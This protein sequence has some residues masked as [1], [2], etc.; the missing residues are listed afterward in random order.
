MS[1]L[2]AAI[3]AS[4]AIRFPEE[5]PRGAACGCFCPE[6]AS[7]LIARQGDARQWHF[8]H[9]PGQERPQCLV[10]AVNLLHRITVE[11][12]QAAA[13]LE[14]PPYV[15]M[16]H[17]RHLREQ[18]SWKAQFIPG[19]MRWTP[20]APKDAPVATGQLDN[21][22]QASLLVQIAAVQPVFA[23]ATA[24]DGAQVVFWVPVP[25]TAALRTLAGVR[26]HIRQNARVFWRHQPDVFGLIEKTRA[27]LLSLLAAND[28]VAAQKASAPTPVL[29]Q[30]VQIKPVQSA[31]RVESYDWAP[32]KKP[33]SS[34][35]YYR[36]KDGTTW[37]VYTRID[38]S[39]SI[40]P[41]PLFEGWDEYLPPS[42]GRPSPQELMYQAPALIP[43]L[44]FMS[45]RTACTR[46]SSNPDDFQGL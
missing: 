16:V 21:G 34:F 43:V 22:I 5:V 7:P 17:A 12:L 19:S 6:C 31:Q 23:P 36:L 9:E 44:T 37:I 38:G 28:I 14:L 20:N 35:I 1:Q 8:A 33:A 42:V 27:R 29:P 15:R 40:V 10:G 24:T 25:P 41:R 3:D 45:G 11:D 39:L 26:Q 18:V 4:G 32:G 13:P 46:T 2:F 30:P